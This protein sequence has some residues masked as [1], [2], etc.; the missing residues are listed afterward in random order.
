MSN[1]TTTKVKVTFSTGEKST[2]AP[3]K[4]DFEKEKGN[5]PWSDPAFS[6]NKD[7]SKK[8]PCAVHDCT[9]ERNNLANP[10][11]ALAVSEKDILGAVEPAAKDS[12]EDSEK[13][14]GDKSKSTFEI[15]LHE[16]LRL[17]R[18]ETGQIAIVHNCTGKRLVSFKVSDI[19]T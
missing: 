6:S 3:P 13:V 19:S 16:G 10:A 7:I 8:W 4:P 15:E 9:C 2:T 1:S 12:K 5:K 18:C 14:D 17:E 11:D